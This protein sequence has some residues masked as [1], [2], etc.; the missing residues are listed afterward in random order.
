MKTLL[1]I[2]L[3]IHAV[4]FICVL[5][6]AWRFLRAEFPVF[7]WWKAN[8]PNWSTAKRRV[9]KYLSGEHI[10]YMAGIVAGYLLAIVVL[11]LCWFALVITYPQ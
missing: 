5:P 10:R 6:N 2:S 4:F 3:L 8:R 1:V 9:R 11:A 7:G